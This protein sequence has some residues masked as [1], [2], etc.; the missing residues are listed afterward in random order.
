MKTHA[1][2]AVLPKL[3]PLNDSIFNIQKTAQLIYAVWRTDEG[4]LKEALTDRLHETYRSQL[5]T[6]LS[7]LRHELRA[8]PILG[9]VLS[10]AGSST[11]VVVHQRHL[12]GVTRVIQDWI[13]FK[14]QGHK[15]LSLEADQEGMRELVYN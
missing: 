10:G 9:C 7:E 8:H 14:A 3:V 13:T 1:A 4:M 2:R 5:V 12:A 6:D 15:L 11:M